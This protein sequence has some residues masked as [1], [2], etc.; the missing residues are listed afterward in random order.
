MYT[1]SE[2]V[3]ILNDLPRWKNG[4]CRGRFDNRAMVGMNLSI[5]YFGKIY[6]EIKVVDYIKGKKPKFIVEYK[7]KNMTIRCD[8]LLNGNIGSV[9]NHFRNLN[10]KEIIDGVVY[11]YITNA[12][13]EESLALYSGEHMDEVMNSNWC[14]RDGYAFSG[15]YNQTKK[16]I[17]LHQ[18]DLGSFVDHINN[19]PLDNRIE[20]LR[21]SNHKD[22]GKN[23]NTNNKFGL[24][25]I[26]KNNKGWYAGYLYN[27]FNIITKTKHNLEEVKID[28]LIAQ[29]YLGYRHN[30]DMFYLL[31][32]LD[33][34]RIK[35]VEE[36]LDTKTRI[37]NNKIHEEI[38]YN[39][40]I[41]DCGEYKKLIWKDKEMLFDCDEEFIKNKNVYNGNNYWLCEFVENN[42]KINN[43]F[44]KEILNL[45][46]NE[47]LI[48]N[49]HIDHLNNNPSDNRRINLTITSHYGNMCN[50]IGR[51]YSQRKSNSCVVMY[52]HK[53]RFWNLI[54][55]LHNPTFKTEE[56][57]INE[58]NRRREII[59]KYRVK[60][61]SKEEL[62]DLIEYCLDNN[63]LLENG[64]ADLDLGYIVK[65][66]G[67]TIEDVI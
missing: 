65:N 61:K 34:N 1:C 57:A 9:V 49:I 63:I 38:T 24:V 8:S 25:G 37:I 45:R 40:E 5:E 29:R 18:V 21:K 53:Y 43:S 3:K 20:N 59:D 67:L 22:N 28:A 39:H 62:E 55:G 15:N 44:H 52:M 12:K 27:G 48:Y 50:K 46:A 32:E 10:N 6:E 31:D 30:E 56:E 26:T 36:L 14:E 42:R 64:L 4:V 60:L 66:F 2:N 51:G 33:E 11:I 47:Y 54:G 41:I 17:S 19:N 7:G 16:R 23:K 58:V 13:G 35:E